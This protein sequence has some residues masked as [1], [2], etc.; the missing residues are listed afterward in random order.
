MGELLC[1]PFAILVWHAWLCCVD[2]F[3]VVN[4]LLQ[5]THQLTDNFSTAVCPNLRFEE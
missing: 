2:V 1:V 5:R 3:F 4:P